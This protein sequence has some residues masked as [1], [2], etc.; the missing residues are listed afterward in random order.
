MQLRRQLVDEGQIEPA[1]RQ[2]LQNWPR[3]AT[4]SASRPDAGPVD[5]GTGFTVKDARKE[6]ASTCG[7]S[8]TS[9]PSTTGSRS[10]PALAHILSDAGVDFG[11]LFDGEHDD[12]NDVRRIGEEGLFQMLA[13]HNI[14]SFR[15]ASFDEIFTTDPH[16]FNTLRN[17]YPAF[18]PDKPVRHYSQLLAA[19]SATGSI[20]VGPLGYR[21]LPRSVLPGPVQPADRAATAGAPGT[22]LRTGGDAQA[23]AEHLLLRR[24]RREDLDDR[25][26]GPQSGRARAGSAR[27]SRSVSATSWWHA[28]RTSSC[29]ATRS[30]PPATRTASR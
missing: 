25:R 27:R 7:S 13:E 26:P 16:A 8:A 14:E 9:P 1:V 23:R 15:R 12:G 11:M 21:H 24:R 18:G 28:R 5:P 3:R 20:P 17:E 10:C 29:T 4:R 19:C 22:R 2:A 30:R 6:P